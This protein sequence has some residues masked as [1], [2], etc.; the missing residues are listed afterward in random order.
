MGAA[1]VRSSV[2][3]AKNSLPE[4]T[5]AAA[6]GSAHHETVSSTTYS[7]TPSSFFAIVRYLSR[8]SVKLT[9]F[10]SMSPMLRRLLRRSKAEA[11]RALYILHISSASFLRISP[12]NTLELRR[13]VMNGLKAVGLLPSDIS[14]KVAT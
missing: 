13:S 9:F 5:Y 10:S 12:L 7:S 3:A 11:G 1:G 8:Q 4:S 2:R 6:V 14:K